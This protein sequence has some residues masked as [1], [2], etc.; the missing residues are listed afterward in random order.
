MP[1]AGEVIE[2][3]RPASARLPVARSVRARGDSIAMAS[4]CEATGIMIQS[5]SEEYET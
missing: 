5:A 3:G 1:G 2:R 4:D